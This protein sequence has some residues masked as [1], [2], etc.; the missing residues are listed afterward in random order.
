M[1]FLIL[2]YT[3]VASKHKR[4]TFAH[5]SSEATSTL[6]EYSKPMK[7]NKF[8]KELTD[9]CLLGDSD[10]MIDDILG[11]MITSTHTISSNE[12]HL[13][14]DIHEAFAKKSQIKLLYPRTSLKNA[15]P[16]RERPS[17]DRS[18]RFMVGSLPFDNIACDE[19]FSYM[20]KSVLDYLP[21]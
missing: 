13:S 15:Q 10:K 2:I 6:A 18:R 20:Q 4:K 17:K 3:I 1:P 21:F 5:H 8:I 9:A 12:E 11:P 14:T 16:F 19:I 7:Y